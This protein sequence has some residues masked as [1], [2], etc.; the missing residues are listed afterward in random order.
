MLHW[1]QTSCCQYYGNYTAL[2]QTNKMSY[3]EMALK[4]LNKMCQQNINVVF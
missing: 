3:D 4:Y 1:P 2:N